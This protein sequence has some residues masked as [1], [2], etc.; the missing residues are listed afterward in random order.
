MNPSRVEEA[1]WVLVTLPAVHL[2]YGL[3]SG[4]YDASPWRFAVHESGLWALRLTTIALLISP[5]VSLTGQRWIEPSRRALGLSAALYA[6][7]HVW[8]WMRQFSFL[9][10]ILLDEILR[11]FLI[12]GLIATLLMV[13]LAA[14][15][16]DFARRHLGMA[17]WRKLHLLVFPAAAIGWWHYA[18]A[19]RLDRTELYIQG[20]AIAAALI[21]RTMRAF[22]SP[23]PPRK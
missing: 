8:F 3:L 6:F 21:H 18:L 13:P 1:S 2:F 9:W 7:A 15:S 17:V 22:S 10:D 11:L 19:I 12:L 5:F 16:N 4:D 23:P 20:V 14:T